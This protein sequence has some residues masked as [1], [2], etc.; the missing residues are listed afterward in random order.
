MLD[1]ISRPMI[2]IGAVLAVVVPLAGFVWYLSAHDAD[3]QTE[4]AEQSTLVQAVEKLTAIHERQET[5]EQAERALRARLCAQ[6]K[7][8]AEECPSNS[9]GEDD[10]G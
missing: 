10:G 1:R 2:E 4:K 3:A 5:V 8:P 7:L 9:V 6:R